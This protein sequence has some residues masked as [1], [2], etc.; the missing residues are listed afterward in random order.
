[1]GFL[2]GVKKF[3]DR[4]AKQSDQTIS[5]KRNSLERQHS[6]GQISDEEYEE[7]KSRLDEWQDSVDRYRNS[8]G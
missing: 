3:G 1:M 2:D 7:R 8:S 4:L 6:R 5:Q